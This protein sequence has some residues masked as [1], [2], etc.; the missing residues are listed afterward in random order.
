MNIQLL[1]DADYEQFRDV[2]EATSQ[3]ARR[4]KTFVES[5][6]N[7]NTDMTLLGA[8]AF[9][10]TLV[11]PIGEHG[12]IATLA[13][14]LGEGR[15]TLRFCIDEKQ[16]VGSLIFSR[17]SYDHRDA[18]I[19]SP[20]FSVFMPRYDEPYAKTNKEKFVIRLRKSYNQEIS[21]SLFE[22]LMAIIASLAAPRDDVEQ[23]SDQSLA[24]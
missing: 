19:W 2:S 3:I 15:V 22:L 8:K 16:V 11:D 23:Q 10:A 13:T 1:D 7:I 12:Q 14:P 21:D 6:A 4:A 9:V 17:L 5:L 18:A 20:C 24:L